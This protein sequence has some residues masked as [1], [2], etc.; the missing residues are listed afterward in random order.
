M[1]LFATKCIDAAN[2]TNLAAVYRCKT[3]EYSFRL[4]SNQAK[5]PARAK[6]SMEVQGIFLGLIGIFLCD[7]QSFTSAWLS[8]VTL[9]WSGRMTSPS[10]AEASI[11][12]KGE[13]AP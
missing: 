12:V 10:L 5:L 13:L 11:S 9:G 8:M 3:M 1:L 7:G 4:I 2:Q 6:D